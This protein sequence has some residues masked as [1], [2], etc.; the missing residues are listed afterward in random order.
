ML[1]E[2]R[3]LGQSRI[4]A[5]CLGLGTDKF[6]RNQEVM[7]P[8]TFSLPS[9]KQLEGL[10]DRAREL[11]IN[12]L[13]TAPAYGSSEQRIGQILSDRSNCHTPRG[14]MGPNTHPTHLPFGDLLPLL[15]FDLEDARGH[16]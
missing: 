16:R 5:S 14:T 6:G 11:G 4:Y 8:N 7:Y 12:L 2:K 10:L 15:P 13:D 1:V 3:A 9:D